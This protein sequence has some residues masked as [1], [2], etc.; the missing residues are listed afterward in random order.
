MRTNRVSHGFTLIEL[1]VVIAILGLFAG[2]A[3]PRYL[4]FTAKA[5]GS[6]IVADLRTINSVIAVY[7]AKTGEF[8]LIIVGSD[9]T[10]SG[11]EYFTTDNPAGKC[12]VLMAAVPVP[13]TGSAIFPSN[14]NTTV[15]LK[16]TLYVC[17][18]NKF[19]IVEG[20]LFAFSSGGT[21]SISPKT[22]ADLAEGGAGI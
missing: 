3:I 22:A 1:V 14:P 11:T 6:R 15:E 2:I 19:F 20:G 18:P 7:E 21:P 13:P 10:K 12:Y 4:D 17:T 8:P 5:R 9:G 16:D